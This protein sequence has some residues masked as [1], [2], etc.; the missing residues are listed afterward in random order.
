ME[1]LS[2][3]KKQLLSIK[4]L[5]LLMLIAGIAIQLVILLMNPI[6][7]MSLLAFV[8]G[9]IGFSTVVYMMNGSPV[10]GL[11]GLISAF[12]FIVIHYNAGHYA[13]VLDQLVFVAL[14]DLP[15]IV[16][17]RTWGERVEGGVKKLTAGNVLDIV[18]VMGI[19]WLPLYYVYILLGDTQ[20]AIDSLI[21]IVGATASLLV[22]KGYAL[23]YKFWLFNNLIN[24]ALWFGA[25]QHGLSSAS[26]AMLVVT[27][28]YTATDVYA[29]T[30]F[31]K[32]TKK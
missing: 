20:P 15:L 14:I 31:W 18:I 23:S 27:L 12:G 7:G 17:W 22:F 5:P 21:L 3:I 2:F 28:L 4:G 29:M 26:I 30:H 6:T 9:S 11:L 16:K 1:Y 8:A 13:S 24:I 32:P 10:N 25:L 19:L